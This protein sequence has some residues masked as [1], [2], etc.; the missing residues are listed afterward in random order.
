MYFEVFTGYILL[1]QST[2]EK[3]LF[4][5]MKG[6]ANISEIPSDVEPLLYQ[7]ST[8][9]NYDTDRMVSL[10]LS[11]LHCHLWKHKGSHNHHAGNLWSSLSFSSSLDWSSSTTFLGIILWTQKLTVNRNR[12]SFKSAT[13]SVLYT[14]A[15]CTPWRVLKSK[16]TLSSTIVFTQLYFFFLYFFNHY[17][18]DH[19]SYESLLLLG[20]E[21]S[22]VAVL[23]FYKIE[24]GLHSLSLHHCCLIL[25]V[26]SVPGFAC[27]LLAHI[28]LFI[29]V[30]DPWSPHK[31]HFGPSSAPSTKC[32]LLCIS[33][34]LIKLG[35]K[36]RA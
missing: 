20:E 7:D 33:G 23:Q 25:S 35:T 31:C 26:L 19:A 17:L 21:R 13:Q 11:L 18:K 2:G 32:S 36:Q 4:G 28:P 30:V 10:F 27:P 29:H 24:V 8:I 14:I 22:H 3:S 1:S 15:I 6:E 16:L 34:I 5:L 9:K 12:Y